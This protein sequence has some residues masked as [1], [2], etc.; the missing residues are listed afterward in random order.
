MGSAGRTI[1]LIANVGRQP[2]RRAAVRQAVR[3]AFGKLKRTYEL[4]LPVG[5]NQLLEVLPG[6]EVLFA[7]RLDQEIL[8]RGE[9]LTWVHLGISGVDGHLPPG[10]RR[11]GLRLTNTRGI[12]GPHMTEY[13]LGVILA[14]S[15]RLFRCR[16]YQWNRRWEPR[17]LLPSLSSVSGT[18]LG[19]LGLGSVG[20]ELARKAKALDMQVLATKRTGANG[21]RYEGVDEVFGPDGLDEV[22][23][24]SDWLVLLLPLTA[25]TRGFLNRARIG[26][27]KKGAYLVN[28]GRGELVDERALLGA[29][30]TKR[31]AGAA[32]DV[33]RQE[34]LPP[35]SPFWEHPGVLV[36]P[37]I[38]G[39]FPGYVEEAARVF[40]RNLALYLRG[41]E[42]ENLVD[43]E[44]GY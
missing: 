27:I 22:L 44:L 3:E 13:I 23:R 12:H 29:L 24:R 30:E 2:S 14:H 40:G 28:V 9:D 6:A 36:T 42:L 21:D 8:D 16:D 18:T 35:D 31:L 17:E 15:N 19:I 39:N 11:E 37:H 41:Q 25:E 5:R 38:A 26:R 10:A 34:P 43:I 7:F 4:R 33:F 1:T 32:L 20:L